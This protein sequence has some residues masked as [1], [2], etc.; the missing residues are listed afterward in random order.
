MKSCG[1]GPVEWGSKSFHSLLFEQK[2]QGACIG[3]GMSI[4]GKHAAETNFI[5]V[6]R[7]YGNVQTD[8]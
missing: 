2:V 5:F 7:E 1:S 3:G 6:R 4:Q 8:I